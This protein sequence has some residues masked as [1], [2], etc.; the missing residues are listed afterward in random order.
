MSRF[1]QA[2]VSLSNLRHNIDVLRGCLGSNT[3]F[4]A[5]V[6]SNAYGHGLEEISVCALSHG[7]TMLG[8]SCYEEGLRLRQ[9]GIQAPVLL[10]G[11]C[12]PGNA[13]VAIKQNLSLT[14][15]DCNTL[16]DLQNRAHSLGQPCR[17]HLKVDTG[18]NRIGFVT[19]DSFLQ[20]LD[21]LLYC[22]DIIFSGLYT[23]FACSES[24][25]QSFT[26][27]QGKRFRSYVD[28]ARSRGFSPLVH[29]S[30]SGGILN[31]PDLK[32][33]MVRSGIA[34]YGY[35]P[36]GLNLETMTLK[37]VLSLVT[38]IVMVKDLGEGEG[39]SYG[40]TFVADRPMRVATLPTG[41][42]DGYRRIL[43]NRASVLIHGKRAAQ[44][45]TICMNQMI[46]DVSNIPEAAPGDEVVLLGT[47][48]GECITADELAALADTISYE[49]L[50]GIDPY[51]PRSY[52]E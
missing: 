19:I 30:N 4:L 17:I 15:F 40:L 27:L 28:L 51:M 12:E 25:D 33:D 44:I 3:G 22:P 32:F 29:A 35:H 48:G 43:S 11:A 47:Q 38:Q 23:H 14:V 50:T 34:M 13:D 9:A 10:L 37:P 16:Q 8:V 24:K 36:A 49:I 42:E 20:A 46:V 21:T 5:V 39:V 6:K 26:I 31:H 1:T 41:Y 45:G 52:L 2:V 18:M 7:A